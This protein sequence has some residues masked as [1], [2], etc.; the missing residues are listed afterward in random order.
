MAEHKVIICDKCK[1]Q[2][3]VT[4][5]RFSVGSVAS[6]SGCGS[7]DLVEFIDICRPCLARQIERYI[8]DNYMRASL[9]YAIVNGDKEAYDEL[10]I[11]S[12]KIGKR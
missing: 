1:A 4:R 8:K 5:F 6:A 11:V 12:Q 9:L 3:P 7:E 2:E 10:T